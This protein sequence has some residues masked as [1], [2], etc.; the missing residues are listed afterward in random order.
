MADYRWQYP[1]SLKN[2]ESP[3]TWQ[4]IGD[5]LGV[6]ATRAQQICVEAIR[7]VQS[8]EK[9]REIYLHSLNKESSYHELQDTSY[10]YSA[11]S[12]LGGN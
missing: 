2:I 9:L 5:E 1:E 8:N 11:D 6:S 4:E 12:Y 7:K 3:Y 10:K